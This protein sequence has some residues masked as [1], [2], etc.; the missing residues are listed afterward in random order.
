MRWTPKRKEEVV[1]AIAEGRITV[2]EAKE[3]HSLSDEELAT[4]TRDYVAHGRAGLR[5]RKLQHYYPR[6]SQRITR[7]N[8]HRLLDRPIAGI[9]P[10]DFE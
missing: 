3:Q 1:V 7:R 4:W 2:T 6:P 9:L 5:V 8:G 10:G